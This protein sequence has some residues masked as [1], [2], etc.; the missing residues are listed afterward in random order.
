MREQSHEMPR[1]AVGPPVV[2]NSALAAQ[3]ERI[4]DLLE[5]QEANPFRVRAY[6]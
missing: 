2:A 3:F 5:A 4:S 1:H 6:L